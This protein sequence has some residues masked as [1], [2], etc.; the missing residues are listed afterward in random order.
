MTLKDFN[1][2]KIY[3]SFFLF[4]KDYKV[5]QISNMRGRPCLPFLSIMDSFIY[6]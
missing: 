4:P 1:S 6:F 3:M 2:R 5:F